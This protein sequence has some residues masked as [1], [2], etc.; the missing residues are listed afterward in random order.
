MKHKSKDTLDLISPAKALSMLKEGNQRFI[1]GKHSEKDFPQQIQDSSEGQYPFAVV[2]GC[3]DSRVSPE[4]IFDKGVGDIFSI[5]VAGNIVNEDILGSMEFACKVI[6]SKHILVLGHTS[7]G[8]IQGAY[9]D[10]K[11]GNL[12]ALVEKIKP[13]VQAVKESST[14]E[15]EIDKIAEKN[16]ELTI[17][18]IKQKSP[19][20]KEMLDK[21]EI[22]ISG[23][24]YDVSTGEVQFFD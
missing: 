6:G 15:I 9:D 22:G 23:G 3:V 2:L 21:G 18:Q 19:I 13:A 17:E 10:V 20:L 12:T 5:R 24:M 7:C 4:L 1:K 16:V 8:A 11:L 14:G